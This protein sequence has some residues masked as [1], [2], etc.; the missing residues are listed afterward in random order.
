[1]SAT[2]TQRARLT[3]TQRARVRQALASALGTGRPATRADVI[4]EL[5][6]SLATIGTTC[7]SV[8]LIASRPE[9]PV[10]PDATADT[11][12]SFADAAARL[13]LTADTIRRYAAPSS[14]KLCRLGSGVSLASVTALMARRGAPS[15][16]A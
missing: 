11:V 12:V 5:F 2:G 8:T 10:I 13:G 16:A 4:A 15:K 1:M 14:G 6:D 7:I 3:A 9:A